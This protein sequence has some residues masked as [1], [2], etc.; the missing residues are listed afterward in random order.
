MLLYA[1]KCQCNVP[2][3]LEGQRGHPC[4]P[5][6]IVLHATFVWNKA[7]ASAVADPHSPSCCI[8]Y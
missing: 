1:F 8:S 5:T 7:S 6:V 2:N 4:S 3:I